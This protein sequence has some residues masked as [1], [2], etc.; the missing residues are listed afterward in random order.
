MTIYSVVSVEDL[1]QVVRGVPTARS[2]EI[3]SDGINYNYLDKDAD[4]MRIIM[5]LVDP[6]RLT[7]STGMRMPPNHILA[8]VLAANSWNG[9]PDAHGTLSYLLVDDDTQFLALESHI[10]LRG[11]VDAD[12]IEGW[13]RNFNDRINR[14]EE[15]ATSAIRDLGSDDDV[16]GSKASS[17]EGWRMLGQFASGFLKS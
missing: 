9:S 17:G 1:A 7:A 5:V 10:M 16:S 2:V 4:L 12:N 8:G 6:E 15:A 11:G 13:V 3:A 14:F